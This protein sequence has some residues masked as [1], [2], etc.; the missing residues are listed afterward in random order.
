MAIKPYRE[1]PKLPQVLSA[2]KALNNP[3]TKEAGLNIDQIIEELK[4]LRQNL[5][6]RVNQSLAGKEKENYNKKATEIIDKHREALR[7]ENPSKLYML[8]NIFPGSL[9]RLF[10][11]TNSEEKNIQ[12]GTIDFSGC[13]KAEALIGLG[14]FL[15]L[16]TQFI[17]VESPEGDVFYGY[18]KNDINFSGQ[19]RAGFVDPDKNPPYIPIFSGFKFQT[20][21]KTDYLTAKGAKINKEQNEEEMSPELVATYFEGLAEAK[22][23]V[24]NSWI[25]FAQDREKFFIA[26]EEIDNGENLKGEALWNNSEFQDKISSLCAQLNINSDDLKKVFQFESGIN[27]KSVNT[28]SGATGLIQFMP[29]TAKNLGTST[30]E[31]RKMSGVKQLDYVYKY[32]RPYKGKLN[33]YGDLYLA[34]FYPYALDKGDDY[35]IGSEKGGYYQSLVARQNPAFSQGRSLV[36]KKDVLRRIESA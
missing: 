3:E 29:E 9:S 5:R 34:V 13:P 19:K 28:M 32:F 12:E 31:L 36:T 18:R 6:E 20:I 21:S 33:S 35:V 30:F 8:E 7:K 24:D 27:P 10:I 26:D 2:K 23:E 14:D 4:S 1:G 17:K 15:N 11:N 25:N 22:E 16:K